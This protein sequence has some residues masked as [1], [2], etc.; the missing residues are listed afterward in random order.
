VLLD[1]L[2]QGG[3]LVLFSG[4]LKDYRPGCEYR[5]GEIHP[6]DWVNS[7]SSLY[8]SPPWNVG[9]EGNMG[10]IVTDHPALGGFPHG[11]WC[12]APFVPLIHGAWPLLLEGVKPVPIEPI[13]RSIG[14]KCTLVDKAYLFEI[15]VGRGTVL[16]TSL[17]FECESAWQG[18]PQTP[19][20]LH[21]L[22]AHAAGDAAQP[23]AT[24][25]RLSQIWWVISSFSNKGEPF[26][27]QVVHTSGT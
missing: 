18:H 14:H 5:P 8:R 22:L 21:A 3:R 6:D 1:W 11:G 24:L 9:R 17:A 13:I 4:A 10:T 7:F 12:Q 20:L 23:A 16:A 19:Y 2:E 27:G 25:S 15:G 26:R